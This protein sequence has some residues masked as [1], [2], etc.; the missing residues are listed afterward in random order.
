[1]IW[2]MLLLDHST[3]VEEIRIVPI[4]APEPTAL[5]RTSR[6]TP[7]H[8]AVDRPGLENHEFSSGPATALF[9]SRGV[10]RVWQVRPATAQGGQPQLR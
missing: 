3:A 9:M 10:Y 8:Q 4:G 6:W 1:M 5:L 7:E 2:A